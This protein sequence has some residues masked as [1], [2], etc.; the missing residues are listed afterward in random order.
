MRLYAQNDTVVPGSRVAWQPPAS[1]LV[2]GAVLK[3]PGEALL[4]AR[5]TLTAL[6]RQ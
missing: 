4:F 1:G 2:V 3:I 5:Y 6:P